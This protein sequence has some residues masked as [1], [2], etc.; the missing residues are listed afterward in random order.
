MIPSPHQRGD[1]I[2]FLSLS[3]ILLLFCLVFSCMSDV[4]FDHFLI[5]ILVRNPRCRE[6]KSEGKWAYI[7]GLSKHLTKLQAFLLA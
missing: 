7:I 2:S 4:V 3:R 6:L 1:N 5:F